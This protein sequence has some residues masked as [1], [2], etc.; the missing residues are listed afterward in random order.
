MALNQLRADRN[1]ITPGETDVPFDV[2]C[3]E[4]PYGPH[5]RPDNGVTLSQIRAYSQAAYPGRWR[6][7][8]SV[9][10]PGHFI[11]SDVA[12]PD[13]IMVWAIHRG[14]AYWVTSLHLPDTLPGVDCT[15]PACKANLANGVLTSVTAPLISGRAYEARAVGIHI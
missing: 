14:H 4:T 3:A 9:R 6:I 1:G 8:T 5:L 10:K 12:N 15:C 11:P 2:L 7:Y 13:P